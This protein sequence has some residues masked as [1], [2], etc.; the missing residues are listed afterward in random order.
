MRFTTTPDQFVAVYGHALLED[1]HGRFAFWSL[2][3]PGKSRF[4]SAAAEK[5]AVKN[6]LTDDHLTVCKPAA[7]K[8][9]RVLQKNDTV[10][11]VRQKFFLYLDFI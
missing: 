3:P 8:F 1:A 4:A 5:R 2:W 10:T 11:G 7:R 9:G 6:F